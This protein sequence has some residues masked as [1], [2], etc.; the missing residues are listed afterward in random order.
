MLAIVSPPALV[1][2][3]LPVLFW[4]ASAVAQDDRAP[5]SNGLTVSTRE[6]NASQ[7]GKERFSERCSF[8]HGGGGR[9]AKG[10]CLTCGRVRHG[11]SDGALYANIAGGIQGTQMGAF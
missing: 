5:G 7:A 9:G 1:A 4:V 8:C 2:L 6:A 11:G 3:I 10:P